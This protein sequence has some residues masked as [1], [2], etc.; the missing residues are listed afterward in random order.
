MSLQE[1][2]ADLH[3]RFDKRNI[4]D[5][6]AAA[7]R[8]IVE[9]ERRRLLNVGDRVPHFELKDPEFGDFSSAGLL[10][11][12]PLVVTFYR[13]LWCSLCQ[14]DLL[15]LEQIMPAIRQAKGAAVAVTHN[16]PADARRS[17]HE[18]RGFSFPLMNDFDGTVAEQFGIRWSQGDY[19][20]IEKELGMDVIT[21]RDGGPWI[22]PM[23]ARY[24]IAPGGLVI[25]AD[26][27][28][29]YAERSNP[30]DALSVLRS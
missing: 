29:D 17:L 24:V 8:V 13:G 7:A 16:L 23:Q 30:S 25:F 19:R 18:A 21:L 9:E 3:R 6:Y 12:G 2:F 15:E 1:I 26:A 4:M 27:V 28:F 5:R 14:E 10:Q 11:Q 20:L 22:V